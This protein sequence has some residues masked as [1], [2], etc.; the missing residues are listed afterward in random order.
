MAG[1]VVTFAVAV[2]LVLEVVE[3]SL[4]DFGCDVGV[5]LDN[6][7]VQMVAEPSGLRDLGGAAGDEPGFVAVA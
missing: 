5:D 7:V 1:W 6:T 2:S 4:F 3:E